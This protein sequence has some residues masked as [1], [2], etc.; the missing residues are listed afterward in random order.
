MDDMTSRRLFRVGLTRFR[1]ADGFSFARA[2]A[3]QVV[4]T[5]IPALIVAVAVAQRMEQNE[6]HRAIR[7][8]ADTIAPGPAGEVVRMALEQG[9]RGGENLAV[10]I[11]GGLAVLVSGAS[12]MAQL[13]RAASRIYGI[14]DDRPTL[15]RYLVATGLMISVGSLLVVAFVLLT[16]GDAIGSVLDDYGVV[17]TWGRWP[18]ALLVSLLGLAA[19]FKAA[20]NRSQPSLGWLATGSAI[21]VVSWAA[22]TGILALFLTASGSFGDTYGPLAG[23]IGFLVWSYLSSIAV[24]VGL[25][26]AAQ[27]EAVRAG[28][29]GPRSTFKRAMSESPEPSPAG[30]GESDLEHDRAGAHLEDGSDHGRHHD[31]RPPSHLQ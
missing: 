27:L 15:R 26:Y 2:L 25:A 19:L 30:I 14:E 4:L 1:Y 5:V 28:A 22:T 7:G 3:F 18:A 11:A 12:A 8:I 24:L 9:S 23:M 13:Q 21:A 10:I 6:F 16:V 17:Y 20:P 29:P 31:R